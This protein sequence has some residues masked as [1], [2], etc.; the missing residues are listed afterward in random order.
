MMLIFLGLEMNDENRLN[1][2][3]ICNYNYKETIYVINKF[4]IDK[5]NYDFN[6]PRKLKLN[7]YDKNIFIYANSFED[8]QRFI[9][10]H[11]HIPKE[12]QLIFCTSYN[13]HRL[14]ETNFGHLELNN[15]KLQSILDYENIT[16][17]ILYDD[18]L[19]KNKWTLNI[20]RFS[21]KWD[22]IYYLS[23]IY[24]FKYDEENYVPKFQKGIYLDIYSL[25]ECEIKN[26]DNINLIL[27]P[28]L[29]Y[30]KKKIK[31]D[32]SYVIYIKTLIGKTIII[33]VYELLTV[34]ELKILIEDKEGILIDQ[35]R[36]IFDGHQLE[37]NRTLLSYSILKECTLHLVLRFRSVN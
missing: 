2:Y 37:D 25:R 24:N 4:D 15:I 1:D 7:Y 20:S 18:N 8:L 28:S 22:L 35:Q 33:N 19:K 21:N 9:N 12:N 27:L 30:I 13:N 17:N 11:F 36:L 23:E 14:D 29:N 10:I 3:Q 5:K 31:D 34:L 6:G 32:E 16:I 26:G